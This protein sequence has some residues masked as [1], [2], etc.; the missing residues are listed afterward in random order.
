MCIVLLFRDGARVY[1]HTVFCILGR[2]QALSGL[3]QTGWLG[4][5][6]GGKLKA[7]KRLLNRA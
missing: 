6:R 7:R 5:I 4:F 1:Q 3:T 2:V